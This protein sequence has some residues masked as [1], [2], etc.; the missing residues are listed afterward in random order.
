MDFLILYCPL[1]PLSLI[2]LTGY[3]QQFL[4]AC[5]GN[6]WASLSPD[7]PLE[8]RGV[9]GGGVEEVRERGKETSINE[10]FTKSG[11]F[12]SSADDAASTQNTRLL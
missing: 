5:R 2:P 9:K 6:F 10:N 4:R 8:S 7:P 1:H 12:I 11:T 3:A